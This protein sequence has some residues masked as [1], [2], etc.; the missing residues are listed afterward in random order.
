MT[1]FPWK[2]YFEHVGKKIWNYLVGRTEYRANWKMSNKHDWWWSSK[3]W[4]RYTAIIIMDS[5]YTVCPFCCLPRED[6]V[7][8]R[9]GVIKKKKEKMNFTI[10]ETQFYLGSGLFKKCLLDWSN[11]SSAFSFEL[12]FFSSF[13]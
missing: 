10:L 1:E 6:N 2:L 13:L 5:Y 3:S 11:F 8:Y 9:Y 12:F 7:Q 4:Y